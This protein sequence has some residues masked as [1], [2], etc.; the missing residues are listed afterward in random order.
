MPRYEGKINELFRLEIASNLTHELCM[1]LL[2]S[3]ALKR[4]ML[5]K[6]HLT[7]VIS[8]M[9]DSVFTQKILFSHFHAVHQQIIL[10]QYL[11]PTDSA[12]F[13]PFYFF[14]F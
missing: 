12:I 6:Q 14:L 13:L 8:D 4:F 3:K 11:R 5:R 10:F 1:K 2:D 7:F 9:K